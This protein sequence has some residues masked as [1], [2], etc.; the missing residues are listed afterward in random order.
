M[1]LIGT[2]RKNGWILIATMALALGGF[3]L[4]DVVSNSQ[5]YSAADVNLLGK[6]GDTEIKRSEFETYEQLVYA[7]QRRG[8]ETYTIR[9]QT[10]NY[11]SERAVVDQLATDMGIG[12]G[13]DELIDLQFGASISPIIAERFKGNDGQP[14]RAQ[15][16]SIKN[17]IESGQFNEPQA[18]A[19]W[20]VQEK[21]VQKFRLQEKILAAISKGMFTPKWQ[22]EMVFK[23]NNERRNIAATRIPFGKIPDSEAQLTDSDFSAFLKDN[24]RMFDQTEETRTLAYIAFDVIPTPADTAAAREAVA[25]LI[26][27]LR[28]TK[29]DSSFVIANGGSYA[30]LFF[31]KSKFPASIADSV[32]SRPAG[33]VIG[34]VIEGN[35]MIIAKIVE[36]RLLPDSVKARHILLREST[37]EN[38]RIADSLINMVQTGKIRFD[39]LAIRR[40]QD[41]GSAQEGGDLGY[42]ASDMMVKEFSDLCFLRAEQ[43]KLYKVSTQFGW[44]IVEVTGKKFITNEPSAKVAVLGR[45]IEPGKAT[46]QAV[47]DKAVALLQTV[48]SYSDLEAKANEQN[49]NL[50]KSAPLKIN[51]FNI[52]GGLG[53]GE[54]ARSVIRWAFEEKTTAGSVS[55]TV[56]S[57]GDPDGGYFDSKYAVVAVKN[58]VPAGKS[59]VASL[60]ANEDAVNYIQNRKK[61]EIIVKQIQNPGDLFAVASQFGVTVDTVR[62]LSF[63]QSNNEPRV[64]GLLATLA[65]GQVS[66]PVVGNVG[67]VVFK[68][69]NDASQMPMPADLTMFR[70]QMSSQMSSMLYTTLFKS[71]MREKGVQDNRHRFW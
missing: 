1:A 40:S 25:K 31:S 29:T 34:P 62:G 8:N 51:D 11:F 14:N 54:N 58:V 57:F 67:V 21:E 48:K 23:E 68:P 28:D 61:G 10:W 41:P 43:G 13:K 6:V 46:Q 52:G 64:A 60:K 47:K 44:H 24:P 4:M 7:D 42:F 50:Q 71:L 36:R 70:R 26:P 2:I 56:F 16:A 66:E 55:P 15:L 39:S 5:R 59:S 65:T 3:I 22:A 45:R 30:G 20:S 12:V 18:R 9:N 37:P 19:Y 38:E 35:E 17:A 69:L 33:S 53:Q 49:L 63:M 27:G 32:V